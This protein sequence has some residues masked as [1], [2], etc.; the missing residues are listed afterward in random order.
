MID[1]LF[2]STLKRITPAPVQRWWR[3]RNAPQPERHEPSVQRVTGGPLIDRQLFVDPS[4]PAFRDML[5]GGYDDFMWPIVPAIIDGEVI[6]D[7]GA[8][9]GFHALA[10][11]AMRPTAKVIA[12]EPNPVNL[13]RLHQNLSLDPELAS[14]VQVVGAALGDTEGTFTFNASGNVDDQTSSGGYLDTVTPPLEPAIYERSHF[15]SFQ[16][17]VQRLDHLALKD[18][19]GRVAFIKLDVEGAEH[20]VLRGAVELLERDKPVLCIEV[21]SVNCMLETQA[22]LAPLGYS[23]RMLK[24]DRPSRAHVLCH[25]L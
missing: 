21:H 23:V 3:S 5:T 14:R 9:I 12:F 19:W 20:L 8:H 25:P 16:V 1:Q 7:I 4:R 22:V 2:R 11:A 13:Q 6:L 10:F 17:E 24:E 18:A 15:T